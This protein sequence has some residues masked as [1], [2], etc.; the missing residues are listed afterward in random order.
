VTA[1][2]QDRQLV[3]KVTVGFAII[4]AALVLFVALAESLWMIAAVQPAA[5]GASVVGAA[6]AAWWLASF[7]ARPMVSG[8]ALRAAVSGAFVGVAT[9]LIAAVI[10]YGVGH[11]V[12]E[13]TRPADSLVGLLAD[14]VGWILR[15]GGVPAVL[16]GAG[17]G[18]LARAQQRKRAAQHAGG[19]DPR[20]PA[21]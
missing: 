20:G 14:L 1:G 15:L 6:L 3:R 17:F 8:G 12:M 21:A 7:A 19:P 9:L 18:L 5:L 11:L 10:G 4:G 13:P 16:L 2:P